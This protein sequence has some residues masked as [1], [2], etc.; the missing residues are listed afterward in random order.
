MADGD[1]VGI[2]IVE[3][4]I[5]LPGVR[6]NRR[7]FLSKTFTDVSSE[8]LHIIMEE[9]PQ[10]V[11]STEELEKI[12][13]KVIRKNA[14]KSTAASVMAGLPS[15]P[16]VMA[17]TFTADMMQYYGFALRMAQQLGYLYGIS[18]LL[19]DEG[20]LTEEG[21]QTLQLYLAVMLGISGGNAGIMFVAR[22]VGSHI[23]KQIIA[24]PVTKTM[25]Y[26]LIKTI[27]KQIGVQV[28]KKATSKLATKAIPILGG[29]VSGGITYVSM[30]PMGRKLMKALVDSVNPTEEDI[31][32]ATEIIEGI[33]AE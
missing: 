25:W 9:G 12:A 1:N 23:G 19:S 33:V 30:K 6:M 2:Q 15:N 4:V 3:G 14:E 11:F 5:K 27:G 18:D 28:T 7:E 26:P 31:N 10:A 29:I 8:K 13:D 32:K 20:S 22:G 24:K 21:R 17:G 16:L